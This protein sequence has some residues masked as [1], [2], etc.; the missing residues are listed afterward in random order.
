MRWE[1]FEYIA[2]SLLATER[3]RV[4]SRLTVQRLIQN[5]RYFTD[6]QGF[7]TLP[8]SVEDIWDRRTLGL[9]SRVPGYSVWQRH[10]VLGA[11]IR[12]GHLDFRA[13]GHTILRNRL[14]THGF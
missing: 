5:F 2:R 7:L 3:G 13:F 9:P 10:A 1:Y 8:S 14:K 6:S 4:L 11:S 12:V